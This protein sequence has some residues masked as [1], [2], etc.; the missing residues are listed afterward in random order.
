MVRRVT[1]VL[2]TTIFTSFPATASS[3]DS[4]TF[5][6]RC[7]VVYVR[8]CHR[9]ARCVWRFRGCLCSAV[10]PVPFL[11]GFDPFAGRVSF[12]F[13]GSVS[14]YSK[15]V[16]LLLAGGGCSGVFG[17]LVELGGGD[18]IMAV[19]WWWLGGRLL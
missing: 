19:M 15:S 18:D 9:K 4:V 3:L 10:V 6:R 17:V 14:F 5:L 1:A 13:Y 12:C 7:W 8:Q 16:V 11:L 2:R